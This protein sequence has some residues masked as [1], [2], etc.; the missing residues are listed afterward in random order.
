MTPTALPAE[1]EPLTEEE[2][3]QILARLPDLP[4]DAAEQVDFQLPQE[5]IPP[6]RTGQ[7]VEQSFPPASTDIQQ[8]TQGSVRAAGSA[9]LCARR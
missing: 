3:D 1:K 5:P 4:E 2:I 7:T 6:P 8:P 9:A